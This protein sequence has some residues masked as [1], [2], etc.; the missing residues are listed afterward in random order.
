MFMDVGHAM[1]Y[2]CTQYNSEKANILSTL[3][4]NEFIISWQRQCLILQ[5]CYIYHDHCTK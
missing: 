3:F 2:Q 4:V 5:Y 1:K